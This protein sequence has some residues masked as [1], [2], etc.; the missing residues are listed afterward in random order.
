MDGV[1]NEFGNEYVVVGCVA[2]GATNDANSEGEGRHGC[3]EV[4]KGCQ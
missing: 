3:D 1:G 4:L 2:D